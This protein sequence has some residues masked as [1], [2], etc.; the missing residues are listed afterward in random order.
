MN[1]FEALFG[2][3]GR[4]PT[5]NAATGEPIQKSDNLTRQRIAGTPY[6]VLYT[7]LLSDER[8]AK[9]VTLAKA[10]PLPVPAP[11]PKT[12]KAKDE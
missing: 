7:G 12:P 8:L 5:F 2:A 11:T 10:E 6:Y 1:E 9:L 3:K 4:R